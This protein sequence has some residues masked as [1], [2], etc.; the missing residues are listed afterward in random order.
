MLLLAVP[1]PAA[2][3][4]VGITSFDRIRV[5]GPYRVTV[6]TGRGPSARAD[7][8]RR[9]LDRLS[10]RV[11]GRTL[12]IRANSSAWGGWT[13]EGQGPVTIML[14]TPDLA[15]A[16]LVGS[17]SL[18]I[19]RMKGPRVEVLVDGAGSL[20][21]GAVASDRLSA[22]VSGAG[23]VIVAGRALQAQA[24]VRG[25]GDL[26][27]AAVVADDV[28]L[29]V[30]GAAN[31]RIRA[32]RSARIVSNSSGDVVVTGK[33]ACTV[34]QVGSGGVACGGAEAARP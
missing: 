2:Q 16:S 3:Q 5:D 22:L 33:A 8:D 32:T 26:D 28:Q 6:V 1:L 11:E 29:T 24:I 21:V 12:Q 19:D 20:S 31:A 7:G 23:R 17:G 18:S 15:S 30:E 27:A 4:T 25:T 10:L 13:G 34:R 9:S 14:S